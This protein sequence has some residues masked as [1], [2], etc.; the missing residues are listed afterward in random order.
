[1]LSVKYVEKGIKHGIVKRIT[2]RLWNLLTRILGYDIDY[3][4][5]F[6]L[7]NCFVPANILLINNLKH[8]GGKS[9][10][11]SLI[12]DK[13][14]IDLLMVLFPKA[15]LMIVTTNIQLWDHHNSRLKFIPAQEFFSLYDPDKT[16]LTSRLE[17]L[18]KELGIELVIN[19]S[20]AFFP[21]WQSCLMRVFSNYV[22]VNS[23]WGAVIVHDGTIMRFPLLPWQKHA[24]S[25][26]KTY[27]GQARRKVL[28]A[29]KGNPINNENVVLNV[30]KE[31]EV[32]LDKIVGN[33]REPLL[34]LNL[35]SKRSRKDW[36]DIFSI[37]RFLE[38]VVSKDKMRVI[39]PCP[40][41]ER[42]QILIDEILKNISE[43]IQSK[44]II[45]QE[46]GLHVL[47]LL[48]YRAD[49]IIT[50]DTGI[51]HLANALGKNPIVL[52]YTNIFNQPFSF[53]LYWL[54]SD[55]IKE[56]GDYVT[57][58]FRSNYSW[59]D[60]LVKLRQQRKRSLPALESTGTPVPDQKEAVIILNS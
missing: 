57:S 56:M 2:I 29:P 6:R 60:I 18:K 31:D 19:L 41:S 25:R 15:T 44:I 26:R 5:F 36:V 16:V 45:P 1:M 7:W 53:W 46:N 33:I 47:K 14:I 43:N 24:F 3:T 23:G 30:Q 50:V 11:D 13:P 17:S 37:T 22:A 4:G 28:K 49:Y 12:F 58:F 20:R 48:V 35:F 42:E 34:L 27:A 52:Y 55:Y 39:I 8:G 38:E 10:G 51:G 54:P 40:R 9:I 59:Q 21:N 32:L